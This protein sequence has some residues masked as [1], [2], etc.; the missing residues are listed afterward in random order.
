MRIYNAKPIFIGLVIFFGFA[1]FPFWYNGGRAAPPP[2]PK[3]DT[4]VIQKL[5]KKECVAS[6]DYMR[7]SHMDL[8][9]KWRTEAVRLANRYYVSAAG[10]TYPV[11]LQRGCMKCHSNKTEFC[12]QCHNYI[13]LTPYCWDC[14]I[15][16]KQVTQTEQVAKKG[17]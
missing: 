7:K 8:L 16:P 2:E 15:P 17:E 13:G 10:K 1:T 6:K 3:L 4:P 14:H 9:N 12:D 11:S 5:E